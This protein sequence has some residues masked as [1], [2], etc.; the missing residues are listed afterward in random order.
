MNKTFFDAVNYITPV[1]EFRNKYK[2]E[3]PEVLSKIIAFVNEAEEKNAE[4]AF[5]LFQ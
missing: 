3:K 2:S 4:Q 5:I 1:S